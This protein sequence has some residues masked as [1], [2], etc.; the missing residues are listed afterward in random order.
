MK[1]YERILVGFFV[2]N[3]VSCKW[4]K[5][6]A[7]EGNPTRSV[8]NTAEEWKLMGDWESDCSGSDLF[9]AHRKNIYKFKGDLFTLLSEFYV[10]GDDKCAGYPMITQAYE[11]T[12]TIDDMRHGSDAR[13]LNL[14]YT[15]SYMTPKTDGGVQ[16]LKSLSFCGVKDWSKNKKQKLSDRGGSIECPIHRM[17]QEHFDLFK[18]EDDS[19]FF[20]FSSLVGLTK[21]RPF[22]IDRNVVYKKK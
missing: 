17:P 19:L 9:K 10:G 6:E 16:V 7:V 21:H 5:R 13:E 20:G 3:F 18:I 4:L 15:H 8:R 2:L 14:Y 12:F 22:D 1:K 11:G